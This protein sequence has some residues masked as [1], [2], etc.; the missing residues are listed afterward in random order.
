MIGGKGG[1]RETRREVGRERGREEGTDGIGG[2]KGEGAHRQTDR[3]GG[4][5]FCASV[6]MFRTVFQQA[7]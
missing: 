2:D 4:L 1:E 7:A 6:Q 3:S 5:S